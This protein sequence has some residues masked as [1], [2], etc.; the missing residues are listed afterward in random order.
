KII[1]NLG[2]W[3]DNAGLSVEQKVRYL[4]NENNSQFSIALLTLLESPQIKNKISDLITGIKKSKSHENTIIS[5]CLCQILGIETNR[6]I[7]SDL[8]GN[9]LI[10][11]PDF[12]NNSAFKAIFNFHGGRII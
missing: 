8:A 3:G 12:T 2:L 10:Y 5:I 4:A 9:D 1:D 7:I 6:G 11:D